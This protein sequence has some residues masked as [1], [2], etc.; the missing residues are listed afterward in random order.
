MSVSLIRI[1]GAELIHKQVL[2][3]RWDAGNALDEAGKLERLAEDQR[4][5]AAQ[6]L[7]EAHE[8]EADLT[9]LIG[10]AASAV[11]A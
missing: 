7:A 8:L 1:T 3:N 2:K 6:L 5:H 4:S 10:E 11:A 9:K